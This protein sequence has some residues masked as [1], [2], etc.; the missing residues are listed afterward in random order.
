M[1]L[2]DLLK[3]DL[4]IFFN[5]N[6]HA[7]SHLI[8]DHEFTIIVDEFITKERQPNGLTDPEGYYVGNSSFQVKKADYD[9]VFGD[10]PKPEQSIKL[11]DD[12]YRV[13][14]CREDVGVYIITL[15]AH[16]A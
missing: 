11:D 2:K 4:S 6:E 3:S 15:G 8:D 12:Y 5:E 9:A 14:D 13:I 1:A 7:E 10:K 16:D